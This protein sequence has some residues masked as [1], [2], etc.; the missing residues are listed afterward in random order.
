[1]STV[2]SDVMARVGKDLAMAMLGGS[3]LAGSW[4]VESM[5][6]RGELKSFLPSYSVA[7]SREDNKTQQANA[8]V[9][10]DRRCPVTET[11]P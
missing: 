10:T 2:A 4:W 6:L 11:K 5:A 9:E 7:C 8:T 1:M 3:L